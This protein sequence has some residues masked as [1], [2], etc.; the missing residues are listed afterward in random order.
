MKIKY[1]EEHK[2]IYVNQFEKERM[3]REQ[4]KMD[5]I[6]SKEKEREREREEKLKLTGCKKEQKKK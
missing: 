4:T 2:K 6:K 1:K 5:Q 3:K